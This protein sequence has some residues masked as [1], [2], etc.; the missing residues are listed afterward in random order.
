MLELLDLVLGDAT[1]LIRIEGCGD[2]APSV[3]PVEQLQSLAEARRDMQLA[4][5][6]AG[7]TAARGH[8]VDVGRGVRRRRRGEGRVRRRGGG[9]RDGWR[10]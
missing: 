7:T 8:G 6:A 10:G 1:D 5:V 2:D 3:L 4:Q 9:H